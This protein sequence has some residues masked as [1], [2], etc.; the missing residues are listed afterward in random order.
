MGICPKALYRNLIDDLKGRFGAS[1]VDDFSALDVP[2]PTFSTK[3]VAAFSIY[4]SLL[5]KYEV[6]NT[7]MLDSKALLKFLQINSDC[8]NWSLQLSSSWDEVLI[9]ELK[10]A[11]YKFFNPEGYP[12]VTSYDQIFHYGRTGPGAA[13][14]AKG[15][16]FYTKMFASPLSCTRQGLYKM[17]RNYIKNFPE[18]TNAENIRQAHFG[19][20]HVVSGSRFSFVPKNDQ[21]SRTICVEPSLNMFAQLGLGHIIE[22]RLLDAYGISMS[23]QPYKN[24]EL[25]RRGSLGLGFVTC[26]LSSASDSLSLRMLKEVLPHDI[27][28]TLRYLRSDTTEIPGLGTTELHMVSTMGNGFTFPL[29]TVLF[30]AVV[31]A[32]ARARDIELRFPRGQDFGTWGVFGDDIICPEKIWP[33]VNRLLALLGFKVNHDKTF[34]EGPFRESCG[35]DYHVGVN[36]RGVYV[37]RLESQQDLCSVVN[38]LNLFSTRTGV[39]LPKT[40]AALLTKVRWQPVPRWENSDAGIH[41]PLSMVSGSLLFS[42][43]GSALYRRYEPIGLKARILESSVVVPRYAKPRIYNPSGLLMSFL[44]GSINSFSIGVRQDPVRYKRKLGVAPY[45]DATPTT[46]PSSGWFNW[47]RWETAVYFNLFG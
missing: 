6:R 5:K 21:I 44:Q 10:S 8:E 11:L 12:L 24:R 33:D 2:S 45:W 29:Q 13:I 27:Y 1:F 4:R 43:N 30:S 47:Q 41:V 16:D 42:E 7:D 17:Y 34:V 35:A 28:N 46:H 36:V 37:K 3:E 9:G 22:K 23:T 20:A 19:E 18:W 15:G 39:F 25:A 38:Q 14:G 31:V 32:A 26:D 40:C